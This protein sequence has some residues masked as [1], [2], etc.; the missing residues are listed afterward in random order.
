MTLQRTPSNT[1][2][3]RSASLLRAL[4]SKAS[5]VWSE[6]DPA[7]ANTLSEAMDTLGDAPR[8]DEVA[9]DYISEMTQQDSPPSIW[10]RLSQLHVESL[11]TLLEGEHPQLIALTLSQIEAQPAAALIRRLPALLATDVLHRMLHMAPP[12]ITALA[13]IEANFENRLPADTTRPVPR[14][15]IVA[16]IFEV[17]P[18][19]KSNTLLT[20]LHTIEPGTDE[21]IKALMFDFA[22]LAGLPPA[23][24]QTLL[25]KSKRTTLIKALKGVSEKVGEAFYKN[26]TSRARETLQEEVFALGP[27]RRSDVE[28]A[29]AELVSLARGLVEAGEILPTDAHMDEDLIT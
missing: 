5:A 12:R 6:L 10:M 22:D 28:A 18:D 9:S 25:A 2:L 29:R 13:A 27:Q 21:R 11:A 1:G 19:E 26:M 4:G 24:M 8:F 16:R 15:E 20:A 14:E 17:L 3:A 23:G 7:D